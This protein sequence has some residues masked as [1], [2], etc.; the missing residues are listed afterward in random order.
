M[1]LVLN[2]FIDNVAKED[3]SMLWQAITM[4]QKTLDSWFNMTEGD[5]SE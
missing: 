4:A 3:V 2:T 5:E 1:N